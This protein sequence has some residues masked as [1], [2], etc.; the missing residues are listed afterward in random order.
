MGVTR[1]RDDPEDAKL[2][3]AGRVILML[4]KSTWGKNKG[5]HRTEA[6]NERDVCP[7]LRFS[8]NIWV[9]W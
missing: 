9:S 3:D 8:L 1:W 2:D 7:R 5:K 6:D 4:E